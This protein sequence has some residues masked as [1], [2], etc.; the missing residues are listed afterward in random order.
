MLKHKEKIIFSLKSLLVSFVI[1]IIL[2]M[3]FSAFL[4]FTDLSEGKIPILNTVIMIVS[5]ASGSI[6]GARNI[7]EKGY[8]V[9]GVIG[10]VYYLILLLLSFL[11]LNSL[12]FTVFSVTRLIL[13]F[14]IG[15][16]GGMIGINS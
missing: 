16:I 15:M 1:T 13:A 14:I 12:I 7:K 8:I 11:F 2:L 9:G 3:I 5:I 10:V 4:T 6:Y